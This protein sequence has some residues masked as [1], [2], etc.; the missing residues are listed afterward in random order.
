MSLLLPTYFP[1]LEIAVP[2]FLCIKSL[3]VMLNAFTA[4]ILSLGYILESPGKGFV[5]KTANDLK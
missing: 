2:T 4:K 1:N 3:E 5:F